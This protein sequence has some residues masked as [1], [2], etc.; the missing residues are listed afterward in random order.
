MRRLLGSGLPDTTIL[1][2]CQGRCRAMVAFWVYAGNGVRVHSDGIDIC[3][4]VGEGHF[5][6]AV[7][8]LSSTE[9]ETY[10]SEPS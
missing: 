9:V 8:E 10:L 1:G 4:K 2:A 7:M 3:K 5:S 6:T